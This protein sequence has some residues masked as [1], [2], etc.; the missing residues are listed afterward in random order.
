M[1]TD[2]PAAVVTWT[3]DELSD[4][5]VRFGTAAPPTTPVANGTLLQNHHVV[6][7]DLLAY[8]T[9]YSYEVQSTDVGS[10]T[11]VDDNG[12]A[13]YTFTIGAPN[14]APSPPADPS[15]ENGATGAGLD[16]TL[17]VFV[18]DPDADDMD[19]SFYDEFDTLIGTDY[20]VASGSRASVEWNGLSPDTTYNWYAVATDQGASTPSATWAFTTGSPGGMYVWNIAWKTKQA[21]SN[22]F[23]THIVTV[24]YDSDHDG[25]AE[26]TDAL[27]S[28]ATVD[29][30]LTHTDTQQTWNFSGVT[31][32]GVVEF[33]QKVS[34]AGQYE[35]EVMDI[36]HPPES[37][38][39]E[40]DQNNPST[41][42]L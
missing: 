2:R 8:P 10:N 21:G 40:M 19:V 29:S 25:V 1:L 33:T 18:S 26:E 11:K 36:T 3:T 22:T 34:D 35:A 6:L 15:P 28:D 41:Y 42:G 7:R 38:T 14:A 5:L 30:T 37:Y 9:V 13:Y 32:D 12:G 24:H 39:P 27:V 17:S 23:L 16:V 31:V 20:A 4:S